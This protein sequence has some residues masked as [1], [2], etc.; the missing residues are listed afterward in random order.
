LVGY[1]E[2]D[3]LLLSAALVLTPDVKIESE[4]GCILFLAFGIRAEVFFGKFTFSPSPNF[5]FF[6]VR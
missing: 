1:D 5:L 3:S 6:G 4:Y 2:G